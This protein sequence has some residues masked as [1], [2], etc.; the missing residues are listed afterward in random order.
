MRVRLRLF[1]KYVV[2]FLVLVSG[3][4]VTS[5]LVEIYFSYQENKTALVRLQRE[6]AEAA[7]AKIEQFIK[8]I[9]RQIGWTAQPVWG[10]QAGAVDQRRFD[11]LRLLRQV[12]AI[13]EISLLDPGGKEQLRVSRL[14]MDVV[15]SQTD[16][17]QEPKFL[18]AKG[19]R[20]PSFHRAGRGARF[21]AGEAEGTGERER[22]GGLLAAQDAATRKRCP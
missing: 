7:A 11:Y 17:S 19:G 21:G 15:G 3:G 4:L 16:F 10:A 18:E 13:T 9:E 12:P 22:H 2:L 20:R 6:K 8:E 5:A 1:W 14:A